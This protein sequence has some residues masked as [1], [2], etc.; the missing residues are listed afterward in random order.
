MS[1]S[2]SQSR[3]YVSNNSSVAKSHSKKCASSSDSDEAGDGPDDWENE[4]FS[5]TTVRE[6]EFEGGFDNLESGV[7]SNA[8]IIRPT[9]GPMRKSDRQSSE[10]EEEDS[11]CVGF[12]FF[13]LRSTPKQE[14]V[15]NTTRVSPGLGLDYNI[16]RTTTRQTT[17]SLP[18]N[19]FVMPQD[20]AKS[21]I[22]GSTVEYGGQSVKSKPW[23]KT[24]N[25]VGMPQDQAKSKTWEKTNN[26]VTST[27]PKVTVSYIIKT[28]LTNYMVLDK[29]LSSTVNGLLPFHNKF[30]VNEYIELTMQE[31]GINGIYK[32]ISIGSNNSPWILEKVGN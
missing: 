23:E 32:V 3:G 17:T 21:T 11:G 8:T 6:K 18:K 28:K 4:D 9:W 19:N 24:N 7:V 5:K 29:I 25:N 2:K 16:P 10:S 27:K 14:P 13:G 1:A 12:D 15:Y 30:K 26:N 22:R 20:Q 31:K